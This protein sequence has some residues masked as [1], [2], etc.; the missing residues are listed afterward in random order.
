MAVETL[1]D[2][3]TSAWD[4]NAQLSRRAE[5]NGSTRPCA[6]HPREAARIKIQKQKK[7]DPDPLYLESYI[8][9]VD[10]NPDKPLGIYG[11][12][13]C[14]YDKNPKTSLNDTSGKRVI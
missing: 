9:N 3:P 5:V 13:Q 11:R 7:S 4:W 10:K 2:D 1:C 8:L 14:F 12:Q 6:K